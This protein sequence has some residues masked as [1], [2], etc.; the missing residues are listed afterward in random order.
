MLKYDFGLKFNTSFKIWL[1]SSCWWKVR[2]LGGGYGGKATPAQLMAAAT[3]LAAFKVNRPVRVVL[4]LKSNME[5]FGKKFPYL[6]KYKVLL[7]RD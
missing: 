1:T 6:G 7:V 3:A 2:R 4:D 5:M